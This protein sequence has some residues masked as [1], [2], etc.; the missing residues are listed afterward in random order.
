MSRWLGEGGKWEEGEKQKDAS[1]GHCLLQ[2]KEES[3]LGEAAAVG[4]VRSG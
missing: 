4:V 1:G 3:G 2:R